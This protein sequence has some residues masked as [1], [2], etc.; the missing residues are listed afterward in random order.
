M[1]VLYAR[2]AG[3]W[4]PVVASGGGSNEVYVGTDDPIVTYPDAEIWYDTDAPTY[5]VS[6]A[7]PQNALG[8][9]AMGAFRATAVALSTTE[10]S[11]TLPITY[12]TV[13]GRRYRITCVARAMVTSNTTYVRAILKVGGANIG[14]GDVL[15]FG[16]GPGTVYTTVNHSWLIDGDGRDIDL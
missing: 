14:P 9:V 3:A 4:V 15:M 13:V 16:P 12:K 7:N 11:I 5:D 8:V 6:S 1:G 10:A 2:V